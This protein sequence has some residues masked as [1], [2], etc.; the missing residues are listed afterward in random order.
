MSLC[1][2]SLNVNLK[3]FRVLG[4]LAPA[5][6]FKK[7]V[8]DHMPCDPPYKHT[9]WGLAGNTSAF[10]W[11]HM[12][13]DGMGTSIS[14]QAGHKLWIIGV[15]KPNVSVDNIRFIE[16]WEIDGPN[17]KNY[18]WEAVLLWPTDTLLSWQQFVATG[19]AK[20]LGI[21]DLTL[22]IMLLQQKIA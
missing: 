8:E 17:L 18:T 10:L 3:V 13:G 6:N 4:S 7:S 20:K 12:D 9:Q 11:S 21:C 19:A 2:F 14:M 1:T 5:M 15:S 22:Y 16:D